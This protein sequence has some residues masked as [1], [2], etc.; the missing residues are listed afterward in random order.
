MTYP[1]TFPDSPPM[2][3]PRD[4][5]RLSGHQYGSGGELC[6]EF[7][8][9][10][11]AS[12][13]TGA[14]MIESAYRLLSGER[15]PENESGI[16]RSVHQTSIGRENRGENT[17]FILDDRAAKVLTQLP[18]DVPTAITVWDRLTKPT[19]VACLMSVGEGAALWSQNGPQP[20]H[21]SVAHGFVIRTERKVDRFAKSP[22]DF[23]EALSTEFPDLMA[24]FPKSPFDGFVLL[25]D[26]DRWIA[27]NLFPYE[28]K[29]H[30]FGYKLIVAPN[31]SGRLPDDH[32][33][34]TQKRIA[35]VG[36]GS[37]GSKIAGMLARSGVRSFT[38]VDDD[39]FFEANLVRNDLDAEAIGQHKGDA[40]AARLRN[41]VANTEISVR[42]IALGQ[43]E[44]AGSTESVMEE[45]AKADLLIDATADARAFNLAAAVARRHSKPMVWCEVFAGGI[46]GI[47]ARVRPGLDP[48]PAQARSQIRSWCDSHN[49]PWIATA[50]ATYEV[51]RDNAPPLIANDA[52]VSVIAAHASRF[53]LDV[54]TRE[55]SA[56]PC[57]A[58]AIGL[59]AEWIFQAPF[60][61]WPIDLQQDGE[62]G[63]A[64]KRASPEELKELIAS[65]FSKVAT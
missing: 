35:I 59:A 36:C 61:T 64:Q 9:D 60:D 28:G 46:G 40:L 65:L 18:V 15:P 10:N 47:V 43:Q 29:Q 57:S 33:I 3:Q 63:G 13:V 22:K 34:L 32:H 27:L 8:P 16:V 6:L 17:R 56:F 21:S 42:R 7:R 5:R 19:W 44:S 41:L 51:E 4:G 38:L 11:W 12:S 23:V 54:L 25:G 50:G 14:M 1:S 24:Q 48:I 45:L 2:V 37:V 52:D 53:A 26:Q 55:K 49:K 31:T 58:Y 30:V 20:S 39:L 62:W